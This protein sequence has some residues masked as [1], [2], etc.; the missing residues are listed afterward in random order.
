MFKSAT[1]ILLL[2]RTTRRSIGFVDLN[3]PLNIE[4]HAYDPL[5]TPALFTEL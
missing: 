1:N 4:P 5:K 2:I 3:K